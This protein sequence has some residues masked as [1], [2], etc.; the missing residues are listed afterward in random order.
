MIGPGLGTVMG[1][2]GDDFQSAAWAVSGSFNSQVLASLDLA[3]TSVLE[4]QQIMGSDGYRDRSNSKLPLLLDNL[5]DTMMAVSNYMVEALSGALEEAA[6]RRNSTCKLAVCCAKFLGSEQHSLRKALDEPGPVAQHTI[7]IHTTT[8]TGKPD[9]TPQLR[10][11]N[12]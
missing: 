10:D 7:P 1:T 5:A 2:P 11:L 4:F 8:A 9:T 12:R 6:D 3:P